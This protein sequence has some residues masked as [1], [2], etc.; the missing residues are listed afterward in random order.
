MVADWATE[1]DFSRDKRSVWPK[2]RRLVWS[3]ERWV[4]VLCYYYFYRPLL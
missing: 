4:D 2:E 1:R 3:A